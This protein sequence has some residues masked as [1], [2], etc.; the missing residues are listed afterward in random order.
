MRFIIIIL[1]LKSVHISV[2]WSYFTDVCVTTAILKYPGLFSSILADRHIASIWMVSTRPLIYKSSSAFINRPVTVPRKQLRLVTNVIFK[3]PIFSSSLER[4][5]YLSFFSLPFN[6]IL[7][8]GG[9][10][11][12]TILRFLFFFLLIVIRSNRLAEIRWSI[13]A[14]KSYY[15]GQILGYT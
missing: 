5:R 8:S 4:L 9:T 1:L 3:F 12:S 10:A 13:C 15:S 6:F 7:W 14:S 11:K 2:S